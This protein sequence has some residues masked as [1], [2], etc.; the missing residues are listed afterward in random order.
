MVP[1]RLSYPSRPN[2]RKCCDLIHLNQPDWGE[3]SH[4]LAFE[5]FNPESDGEYEHL[6]IVLN[7]YW[8]PLDFQLPNLPMGRCWARFAD[9][10]QPSTADF[11]ELPVTLP[12]SLN[13]YPAKARSVVV[14]M[15]AQNKSQG[16]KA[17]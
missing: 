3:Q 11:A 9:T 17:I 13:S 10:S 16:G 15:V 1:N 4:S 12:E 8:E 2:W 14:L 6:Y 7:A 5:L